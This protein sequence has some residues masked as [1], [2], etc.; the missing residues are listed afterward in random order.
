MGPSSL[1]ALQ[2]YV[3]TSICFIL[4]VTHGHTISVFS[5]ALHLVFAGS[6]PRSPLR[7]TTPDTLAPS[8]VVQRVHDIL[9]AYRAILAGMVR[10]P[11]RSVVF[12]RLK[13][14]AITVQPTRS[15]RRTDA[16]PLCRR[17][18]TR[19]AATKAGIQTRKI[20]AAVGRAR[21][22]SPVGSGRRREHGRKW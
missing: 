10:S 19:G 12:A 9:H 6:I 16:R 13:G 7:E 22:G 17:A 4:F 21:L 11:G 15:P 1:S 5:Q 3:H 20:I 14:N 8:R 2:S 18:R